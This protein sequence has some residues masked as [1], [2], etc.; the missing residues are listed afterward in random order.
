MKTIK[1]GRRLTLIYL[2]T[3]YI[4]KYFKKTKII[5]ENI[6]IIGTAF[7]GHPE[8]DDL[9]GPTLNQLINNLISAF[10]KIL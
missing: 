5:P 4:S 10:Q 2:P 6:S 1:S 9:R 7:K 3:N 8:T